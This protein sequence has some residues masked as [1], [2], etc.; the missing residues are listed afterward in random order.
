MCGAGERLRSRASSRSAL[1]GDDMRFVPTV[2]GEGHVDTRREVMRAPR[3][4]LD[5]AKAVV[6]LLI[7]A[8]VAF[9]ALD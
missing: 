8:F 3:E 2:R 7:V 5:M 6:H 1:H 4:P 9:V